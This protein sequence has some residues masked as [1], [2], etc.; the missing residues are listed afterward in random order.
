VVVVSASFAERLGGSD[1]AI[2]RGIDLLGSYRRVV[3]VIGDAAFTEARAPAHG[4]KC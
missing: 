3:G 2:D 1:L 4:S